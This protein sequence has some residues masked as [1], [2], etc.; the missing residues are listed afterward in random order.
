[1]NTPSDPVMLMSMLNMKLRDGD[2]ESLSDLC[3]SL[4]LDEKSVVDK[5]SA[6]GFEYIPQIRQFR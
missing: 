6:A 4:G 2:Y 1:M 3:L 5:L